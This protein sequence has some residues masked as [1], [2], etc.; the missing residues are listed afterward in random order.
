M[1]PDARARLD[2]LG[3]VLRVHGMRAWM[4]PDGLHVENP[5]A[6][7]CC[8]LHPAAVLAMEARRDDA[9]R[10]WFW[11]TWRL[12]LAEADHVPDTV[13]A[14]KTLLHGRPGMPL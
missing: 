8:W 11:A 5:Q 14:V 9:G 6:E 3:T 1:R 13:T 4:T 10:P 7:G 12:A 2:A